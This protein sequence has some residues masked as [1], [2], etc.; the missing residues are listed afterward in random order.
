LSA[1]L[2]LRGTDRAISFG[3]MRLWFEI[4]QSDEYHASVE[5]L[6]RRCLVWAAERGLSADPFVLSAVMDS[7]HYSTDGRLAF[8]SPA[9][10]RTLLLEWIP[11]RA[12]ASADELADAPETL[13]TLLRYLDAEGLSDPRGADLRTNL[14]AVDE[15]AGAG[16]LAAV[17]D[18][19][20]W[21]PGKFW[22]LTA[23]ERGVDLADRRASRRFQRDLE[24]G[25]VV[26]DDAVLQA[27]MRRQLEEGDPEGRRAFAQLPV[28]LPPESDLM[29]AAEESVIVAQLRTLAEWAGTEGRAL[30]ST[31]AL[32]IADA[33]S[34]VGLLGTADEVAG[35]RSSTQLY[36][37][38]RLYVWA[39]KARV[40]RVAKGR[41]F[42]V[43]RAERTLRDA[44]A[45][46]RV[47]FEAFFSLGEAVCL[48]RYKDSPLTLLH[49]DFEAI[50]RDLLNTLYGMWL[51][52]PLLRLEEPAW[53]GASQWSRF[54]SHSDRVEFH[55][56]LRRALE[57]LEALGALRLSEGVADRL[58]SKD[59]E[60]DFKPPFDDEQ[61]WDENS[62][63]RMLEELPS[64][65]RWWN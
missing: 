64:P 54:S 35:V 15:I 7:R 50:L 17:S 52:M 1:V 38:N 56:D 21:S 13:R 55:R 44:R 4:E 10:I 47:A 53:L 30:T 63:R 48:P 43:A 2:T 65:E 34:L 41:L 60:P 29:A 40:V 28:S 31:G 36:E 62:S 57:A 14:T 9:Q 58:F 3:G 42:A 27:I 59:M 23:R 61:P 33:V 22:A 24:A 16:Y 19:L 46:W 18:P 20:G 45:L 8:W 11:R 39:K 12:A 32:K 6:I 5:L 51:P 26:Y 25:R 49:R 37:L